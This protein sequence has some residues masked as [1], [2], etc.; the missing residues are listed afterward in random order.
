MAWDKV[1]PRMVNIF[2]GKERTHSRTIE[3]KK[4]LAD[5]YCTFIVPRIP[6]VLFLVVALSSNWYCEVHWIKRGVLSGGYSE[7]P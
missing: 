4:D 3:A 7:V 6:F 5:L 1:S 2:K